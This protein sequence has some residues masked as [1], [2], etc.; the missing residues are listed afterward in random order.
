MKYV[1]TRGGMAPQ[2]FSDILLEGLAPDGGLAVPQQ[3]PKVDGQTLEAWRG[4]SYADLAVEVLSLFATDIPRQDLSRMAHAAYNGEVF[5]SDEIVPLRPL[6]GGLQ[7]LGLS[8]GPTLAFKDMAMQFLGQVFEYVLAKRG[9]TLNIVGATSGDTGSAAEY[10]LRGKRGVGVFML[11]PHGRMSSFQRAQMYSL[12]DENIHNIAVKGVFDQAQD[13]VKALAADLAFKTR[14]RIGAVNSI[15]WARIAAQ[16]VYYFHGWLRASRAPGQE[17]SFAVPSGN[18]GNI[19]SGHIARGMGLPVRRL[20]LATNENNVLEEFFR[21]GIYRPRAP[22]QT[23]ATSSPSMDIS[24]A[25]NFE[26]FVYDLVGGDAER[27]RALWRELADKG[28]FDLSAQRADFAA[29]YGFVSGVSTHEDRLATIRTVFDE[30]GVL[31]DPHTAD[32][33]KVARDFIEPGIPMLVLE[34]ALPAKFSDTIE[35]ALGRPVPPPAELADLESLPQR[36]TVLDC[37]AGQV[38]AFIEAHAK[39]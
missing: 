33:V 30:T 29:R 27:V 34:T 21:T 15:N 35:E 16:V 25:S 4:L 12:Q 24:R 36:V 3:L 23:Y 17:V 38:R 19:L 22:E 11:S 18:F 2:D 14:Y 39:V 8:E 6:S 31:I 10:A 7:L 37:D 32:G 9:T 13:I 5:S 20:V 28:S 26:R 1:S